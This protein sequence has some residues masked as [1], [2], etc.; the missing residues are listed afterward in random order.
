MVLLLR[1]VRDYQGNI[2]LTFMF[3]RSLSLMSMIGSIEPAS[4][5]PLCLF[6]RE[7]LAGKRATSEQ[8]KSGKKKALSKLLAKDEKGV[9]SH[10][11]RANP[12]RNRLRRS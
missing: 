5:S 9:S 10:R 1:A 3:S 8:T 4:S 7:R 6:G 2:S 11:E 12:F